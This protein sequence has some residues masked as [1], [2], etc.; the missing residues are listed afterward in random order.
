MHEHVL[1]TIATDSGDED[2]L[3]DIIE[4]SLEIDRV[5]ENVHVCVL[6]PDI[7]QKLRAKPAASHVFDL[8][9]AMPVVFV[10][11]GGQDGLDRWM[12]ENLNI[13]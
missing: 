13:Q 8:G 9:D 12:A 4:N 7:V 6:T 10:H 5:V 3:N 11:L 1:L 2:E